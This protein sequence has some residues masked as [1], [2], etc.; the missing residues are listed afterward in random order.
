MAELLKK[1]NNLVSFKFTVSADA[2]EKALNQAYN[3]AKNKFNI[4]GFRKGKAPRVI[5]EK[6]YGEGVFYED[7]LNLALPDAYAKAIEELELEPVDRPEIDVE[8]FDKGIDI[9]VK[10]VVYVKPEVELG[11]YKGVAVTVAKEEV[12]DEKVDEE[13]EKQRKLNARMVV[14]D[15]PAEMDDTLTIDFKGSV[16]GEYFEGGTAQNHQLKLG[17]NQFID[18]FEEQLVGAVSGDEK[19]V[20]VTFPEDYQSPDLAGKAAKFEVKVN[21]IKVEELPELDDEFIKD[22]S[23][24]DTLVEYK[25]DAKEK[26]IEKNDQAHDEK[27]RAA[28]LEAVTLAALVDIPEPMIENEITY[29]LRDFDYQLHYQGM[30]LEKYYE[31]TNTTEEDMRSQM[32]GDAENKVKTSLVIEAIAKVEGFEATDEDVERELKVIADAQNTEVKNVREFYARDEFAGIK[33]R[34]VNLKVIEL[35]TEQAVVTQ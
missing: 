29:M 30:S 18:N 26:L 4:P 25:A 23:E 24:F 14:V 3:K 20:E 13:V 10:A 12:T 28:V 17:S 32:R 6:H 21:E 11:D 16:D 15:R 19:V 34:V 9:V 7:G 1:E 2:F 22:I 35:I 8:E 5:I 33:E 27:V 31:F